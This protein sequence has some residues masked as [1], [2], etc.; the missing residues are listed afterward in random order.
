MAVRNFH[1]RV[2]VDGRDTYVA[3]GPA[4]KD[5]G[6]RA[7]ICQRHKGEIRIAATLDA[8]ANPDGHLTL[9]VF[10]G[11]GNVVLKLETER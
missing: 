11:S 9:R 7:T 8:Y 3:T 4:R 5:G 2:D 1:I 10:D 6:M